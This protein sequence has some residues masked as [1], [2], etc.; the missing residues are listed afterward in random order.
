MIMGPPITR[1]LPFS[2]PKLAPLGYQVAHALSP[3]YN[4][5][6]TFLL[7]RGGGTGT[8]TGGF[9]ATAE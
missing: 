8:A 1:E 5:Y 7:Q 9:I 6:T 4:S 3:P 2:S